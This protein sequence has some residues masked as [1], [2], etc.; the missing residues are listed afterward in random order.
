MVAVG[1]VPIY[2]Y[3]ELYGPPVHLVVSTT[4]RST[5][6]KV[7]TVAL[8]L[9]LNMEGAPKDGKGLALPQVHKVPS[10][11]FNEGEMVVQRGALTAQYGFSGDEVE[12]ALQDYTPNTKLEKKMLRKVDL[13]LI[14]MLWLMCVMAYVDRS[15]IVCESFSAPKHNRSLTF[16]EGNADA[17]G[18]SDDIGL[19]DNRKM[20]SVPL[21]Q[22]IVAHACA[23]ICPPD[24][25]LLHRLPCLGSSLEHDP[26]TR[27]PLLVLVRAYGGESSPYP[28]FRGS[29]PRVL[30]TKHIN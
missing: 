29:V 10:P 20:H 4:T 24:L 17:A 7:A 6:Y 9:L 27:P 8:L 1:H 12:L 28:I 3:I 19:S 11:D 21:P 2:I 14:P 18:M 23:R 15:N 26:G 13:S 16:L 22:R 30:E 5:Y 25:N